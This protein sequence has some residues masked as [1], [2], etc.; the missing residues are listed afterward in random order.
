MSEKKNRI[1]VIAAGLIVGIALSRSA[2]KRYADIQQKY[3]EDFINE[4][5]GEKSCIKSVETRKIE[6]QSYYWHM[7]FPISA[8]KKYMSALKKVLSS[9]RHDYYDFL[10]VDV[11]NG[12]Y[13]KEYGQLI[14]VQATKREKAYQLEMHFEA[15]DGSKKHFVR[16]VPDLI[17]AEKLLE[18]I[19]VKRRIPDITKWFDC[20]EYVLTEQ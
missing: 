1:P 8:N 12:A 5:T 11:N 17:Y 19:L 9:M 6:A 20:T 13:K 2:K 18:I 14:Y 3:V 7:M 4:C 16:F 10:T 15:A